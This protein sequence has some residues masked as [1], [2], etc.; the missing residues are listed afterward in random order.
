MFMGKAWTDDE[1]KRLIEF[2]PITN[3]IEIVNHFDGRTLESIKVKAK[4]LGIF[5][6]EIIKKNN[7]SDAKI[8]EKNGMYGK[9]SN[10]RGRNYCDIYG[11]EKSESIKN[12]LTEAKIGSVGLSGEKNGMYGKIPH[13]KGVSPSDEV[14]EKIREG[15]N[16]YWENLSGSEL[17]K[18]KAQLRRDWIIK[19][20]KYS[21]I[22]TVPEKITEELLIELNIPYDKK[23]NIDYYN[24]DFVVDNNVI[25]VQGDYWHANPNIYSDYDKIQE[26]NVNRDKRK[27]KFLNGR[28]YN[29]LFLWEY[30]LKNNLDLCRKQLKK[31]LNE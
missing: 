31:Y 22:D 30:D 10:K 1:I 17:D 29:I 7:R 25:E 18:R 13:N 2:Y 21:E 4:R 24:C 27:L 6:N 8:G 16:N 12:K 28:G 19:R 14:K 26:K 15:V 20:D 5:R 3:N 9:I 23:K 11:N